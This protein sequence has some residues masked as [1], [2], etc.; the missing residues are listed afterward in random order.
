MNG[1]EPYFEIRI[2][3]FE[4]LSY[5]SLDLASQPSTRFFW[6][7]VAKPGRWHFGMYPYAFPHQPYYFEFNVAAVPEART[8]F[9]VI[10]RLGAIALYRFIRSL[11]K[12]ATAVTA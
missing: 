11:N 8:W 6:N 12:A 10:G 3:M 7:D 4:A 9:Q 2:N 5:S 1:E